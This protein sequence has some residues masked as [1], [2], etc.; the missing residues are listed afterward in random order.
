MSAG[1]RALTVSALSLAAALALTACAGSAED[2]SAEGTGA[3]DTAMSSSPSTSDAAGA[4]STAPEEASA[5]A[6][7]EEDTAPAAQTAEGDAA[8]TP[9]E[10][11]S[12]AQAQQPGGGQDASPAAPRADSGVCD[13]ASLTGALQP[14][15][16]GAG[17]V[18]YDLVL[19]NTGSQPCT[20]AGY[21]GV[22]YLDAAGQQVGVSAARSDNPGTPVIVAPGESA[23][24]PL[25]ES[26]AGH[27]G[28][29]CN[30]HQAVSLLVY[31]PEATDSLT[32][33]HT[34]QAC[35]NPK[36]HQLEIQGFGV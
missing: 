22:S 6:P 7:S 24:A 2:D 27:H 15:N 19:T 36:I 35:G 10:G 13:A 17:S 23:S 21:P 28:Q 34:V 26:N 20:L 14:S 9:A 5:A 12:P 11:V 18:Y 31:P 32:V 16:A 8:G 3:D 25:R 30:P 1:T 4:P 29:V 33:A